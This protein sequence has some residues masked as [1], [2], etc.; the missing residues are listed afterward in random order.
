MGVSGNVKMRRKGSN[1]SLT[2][3]NKMFLFMIP[4]LAFF[5]IFWIYPVLQL[6]YYSLTNFNGINYN[7]DF[8]GLKNYAK[9]FENGTVIKEPWCYE[10]L[11][12]RD[13]A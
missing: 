4:A 3:N 12:R 10:P 8:V 9:V 2:F 6:F 11:C 7:F 13:E 1:T 5:L